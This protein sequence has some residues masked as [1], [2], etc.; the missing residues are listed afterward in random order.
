L[1]IDSFGETYIIA[2]LRSYLCIASSP[3]NRPQGSSHRT[4]FFL[5]PYTQRHFGF[6]HGSLQP[7]ISFYQFH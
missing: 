6:R 3:N 1:G 4:H 2:Q 5:A 7:K